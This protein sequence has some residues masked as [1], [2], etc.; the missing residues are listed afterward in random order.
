L[1]I[2]QQRRKEQDS[3]ALA[4]EEKDYIER[5][6][7]EHRYFEYVNTIRLLSREILTKVNPENGA[8]RIDNL[9]QELK[10]KLLGIN[11]YFTSRFLSDELRTAEMYED[12]SALRHLATVKELFS[13]HICL[14]WMAVKHTSDSKKD[15]IMSEDDRNKL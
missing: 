14:L 11:P 1:T 8:H 5:I 2:K 13:T 6:A 3:A 15:R 7:E 10:D 9:L 12:G 4:G